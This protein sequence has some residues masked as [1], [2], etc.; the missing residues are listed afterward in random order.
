MSAIG[1]TFIILNLILAACFLGWAANLLS[2]SA[3]YKKQYNEEVTAH[4]ETRTSLERE[5]S[6]LQTML[7]AERTAKDEFRVARD[8][9]K[10][11]AERLKVQLE[12]Q[13]RENTELRGNIAKI[14]ETLAGY[15][16]TIKM[17]EESK[18]KAVAAAHEAERARD[19]AIQAQ[20]TATT[21]Q[22]DAEE[23]M[24]TAEAS[25]AD[26]EKELKTTRNQVA[27]LDT[28]IKT[29]QAQYNISLDQVTAVPD[30]SGRVLKVDTSLKP[31]LVSLNVGS[32]DGVQRGMTFEIYSGNTYKGQA[33]VEMVSP[34]I[35][36]AL[37]TMKVP[38]TQIS[39]GDTA[40][41]RIQ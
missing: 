7:T 41:T 8:T 17:L 24:R 40:S 21:G 30:I 6:D 5:R 19:Q 36:S 14:T 26:L 15:D 9:F 35:S 31:G 11:D 16:Q 28:T 4:T 22:R 1:R 18:D 25:I 39:Q 20:T 34:S 29:I 23:K 37:I 3:Q 10:N 2:S 38:D 32:N 12:E 27:K 33:R 13:Q